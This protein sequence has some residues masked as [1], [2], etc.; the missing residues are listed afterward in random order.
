MTRSVQDILR[1]P[2]ADRHLVQAYADEAVQTR[3]V[4]AW[5]IPALTSGGGVV[6]VALPEHAEN[7]LAEVVAGGIDVTGA[8]AAGRLVVL[9]AREVMASFMAGPM[10]DGGRFKAAVLPV[11]ARLRSAIDARGEIRAWG[12]MVDLLCKDGNPVA[13]QRLELLWN[14]VIDETGIRLLCSYELDLLDASAHGEPLAGAC[15]GHSTL[16]PTEDMDRFEKAVAD[17]LREEVGP[18]RATFLEAQFGG[19][20]AHGVAMAPAHALLAKAHAHDAALAARLLAG[21]RRHLSERPA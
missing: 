11:L 5:V 8:L 7:V 10:P 16:L 14:E 12:E 18:W 15:V 21:A 2:G 19:A 1:H 3:A 4:T 6:L 13:A 20:R 9:D 17:T